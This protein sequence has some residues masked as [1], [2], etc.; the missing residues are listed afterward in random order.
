M[1]DRNSRRNR[2]GE[3]SRHHE[4]NKV[5]DM[6]SRIESNKNERLGK[7]TESKERIQNS[8]SKTDTAK[9][10]ICTIKDRLGITGVNNK[11]QKLSV[12]S[13]ETT[14][15]RHNPKNSEQI[16]NNS[17]NIKDRLGPLRNNF[18]PVHKRQPRSGEDNES[19]K[20]EREETEAELDNNDQTLTGPV[21]SHIVAVNRSAFPIVRK[22]DKKHK[23]ASN[24]VLFNTTQHSGYSGYGSAKLQLDKESSDVD[25]D[26]EDTRLPSKVIVTPRPLKPLQPTQKR[27]T[28]SLLLRAVAEANQSVV[29]QKN[30]E[31]SLLVS[32]ILN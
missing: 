4:A 27:A 10:S 24:E 2:D 13:Q 15:Y 19:L 22:I 17:K 25:E 29:T 16:G 12:K 23:K 30:P 20:G 8:S 7:T 32:F 3:S 11:V 31:P 9:K 18:R 26:V 5:N 6:R 14:D 28:Q 1:D 21:K